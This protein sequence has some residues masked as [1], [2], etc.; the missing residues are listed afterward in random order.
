MELRAVGSQGLK[1]SAQGLGCMGMSDFY[2]KR[3]E[4]E[5]IATIHHALEL[6]VNFL[7]TSDMYGPF[8]NEELVRKAIKGRRN[9]VVVATKFGIMRAQPSKDGWAPITGISGLLSRGEMRRSAAAD[10][11]GVHRTRRRRY[12]RRLSARE[13]RSSAAPASP[14][15]GRRQHLSRQRV[16]REHSVRSTCSIWRL[17]RPKGARQQ[18]H[19]G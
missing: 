11:K 17:I 12:R 14:Y 10:A 8:T 3:D 13:L 18:S 9:Q 7:D 6:G 2:G 16:T 5:S 1:V 15:F 4:A 19:Q